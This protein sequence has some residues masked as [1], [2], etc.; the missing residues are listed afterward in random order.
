MEEREGMKSNIFPF[1]GG[2]ICLRDGDHTREL[3]L[4]LD[5]KQ[6]AASEH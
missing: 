5:R 1:V 4:S 3:V 6:M 2:G